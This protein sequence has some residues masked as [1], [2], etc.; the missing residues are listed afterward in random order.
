MAFSQIATSVTILNSGLIGYHG[1]SLTNI[2]TSALSVI[3]AGS[4][5]EIAGA[6]FKA[7]TDI[8]PNASSWTAIT[9][10]T[11]AYLGLTPSGTAGSQILSAAYVSTTPVWST[12]KQGWYT[13]AGSNIRIVSKEY[14]NS[15]TSALAKY[16]IKKEQDLSVDDNYLAPTGTSST[17]LF[18]Y[19]AT[20][21]SVTGASQV[22]IGTFT[23]KKMCTLKFEMP[24]LTKS[25]TDIGV[26]FYLERLIGNID[27]QTSLTGKG[28]NA[29]DGGYNILASGAGGSTITYN[30]LNLALPGTYQVRR[31][32][33]TISASG[34]ITYN[35][36]ALVVGIYNAQDFNEVLA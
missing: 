5:I 21:V 20:A 30:H 1:V 13:S 27:A 17:V 22:I 6:F 23:I 29:F 19:N 28:L 32:L 25:T 4:S 35:I 34:T 2:A 3:A 16:I 31:L 11:N 8:T 26:T 36:K 14:K 18:D 10:A 9:T 33:G 15:N 7:D 24:T 12:S